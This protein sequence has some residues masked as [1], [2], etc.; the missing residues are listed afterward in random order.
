MYSQSLIIQLPRPYCSAFSKIKD[1]LSYIH[2]VSSKTVYTYKMNFNSA[3]YIR[4]HPL[5]RFTTIIDTVDLHVV[6]ITWV[7]AADGSGYSY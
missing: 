2:S 6:C 7:D 1:G 5:E 4:T 3:C